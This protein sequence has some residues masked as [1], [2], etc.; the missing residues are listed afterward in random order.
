MH[1]QVRS[2]SIRR[3]LITDAMAVVPRCNF[4]P[5]AESSR[6][7]RILILARKSR[8]LVAIA[9]LS[10]KARMLYAMTAKSDEL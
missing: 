4:Q 8:I 6:P 9:P 10:K 1:E 3:L 7:S 5:P 2:A